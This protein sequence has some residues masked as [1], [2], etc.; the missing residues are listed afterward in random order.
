MDEVHR[1]IKTVLLKDDAPLPK[2]GD[3]Q[4]GCRRHEQDGRGKA[5]DHSHHPSRG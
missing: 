5:E 1:D 3:R 4:G 2:V